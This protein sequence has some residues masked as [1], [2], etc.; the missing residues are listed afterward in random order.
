LEAIELPSNLPLLNTG[1][2]SSGKLLDK[3]EA[4]P[5]NTRKMTADFPPF[6]DFVKKGIL[7]ILEA[8]SRRYQ[9]S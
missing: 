2:S 5:L 1:N 9:A 3:V 7:S 6:R 4:K 8:D